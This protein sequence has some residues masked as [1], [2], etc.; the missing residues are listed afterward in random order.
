MSRQFSWIIWSSV[1]F[2]IWNLW[3]TYLMSHLRGN[4]RSPNIDDW[5]GTLCQIL[6]KS[7]SGGLQKIKNLHLAAE[8]AKITSNIWHWKVICF[9]WKIQ[10]FLKF[11]AS[12]SCLNASAGAC[13]P[14]CWINSYSNNSLWVFENQRDHFPEFWKGNIVPFFPL[15]FR[16]LGSLGSL[17]LYVFHFMLSQIF[18]VGFN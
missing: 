10:A 8:K 18:S 5:K 12:I 3:F 11:A 15:P 1:W 17:L 2:T 4:Y 6:I 14:L 13:F 9:S 7:E 16:Q